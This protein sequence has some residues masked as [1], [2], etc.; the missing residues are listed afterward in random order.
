MT[1]IK[2]A[3]SKMWRWA[4]GRKTGPNRPRKGL[5]QPARSD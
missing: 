4:A 5:G 1:Q 2:G 3:K